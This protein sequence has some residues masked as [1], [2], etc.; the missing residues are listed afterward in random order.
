MYDYF[1]LVL[2]THYRLPASDLEVFNGLLVDPSFALE[3]AGFAGELV[4]KS[5][6]DYT[7]SFYF[8]LPQMKSA[9]LLF[10]TLGGGLGVGVLV[11]GSIGM[12]DI[13]GLSTSDLMA[14]EFDLC[15][16]YRD[17]R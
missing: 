5:L 13:I 1:F 2:T 3:S 10:N 16:D 17:E 9:Y 12:S 11:E 6:P 4:E 7:I 8:S 15:E 14:Y